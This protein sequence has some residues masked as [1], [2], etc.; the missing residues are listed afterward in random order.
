[1]KKVYILLLIVLLSAC[2]SENS[3]N[4]EQFQ[5]SLDSLNT[6]MPVI[7]EEAVKNILDQIPSP[8]EISMLLRQTN[9][10][11]H[12]GILNSPANV[13]RYNTQFKKAL[14][15]GIYGA[16]L[17]YSN[18]YGESM[19]SL[20]YLSAIKSL[21]Q[22]LNIGQFFDLQAIGRLASNSNNLDS[23]LLITTQN[24]ND[25]NHYLQSQ[26]RSNLSLLFLVGGWVEAMGIL[27]D[28]AA[29]NPGQLNLSDGI[30]A[31][32]IV[33]EQLLLLLSLYKADS[34]MAALLNDFQ[35]L[36]I[37]FDAVNIIRTYKESSMEVIDGIVVIKDN[38]LTT[39]EI[40][41]EEIAAIRT[42]IK[43]IATKITS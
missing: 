35:E 6:S 12:A 27:C 20:R 7:D 43:S 18:I 11:Y 17:G 21:A 32:K 34:N 8:L 37:L 41:D 3:I 25:I 19:E 13:S 33:F 2:K 40:T 29:N 10:K 31:Q 42:K 1:M 30:G 36:K 38:S 14:N 26:N 28:V 16:D 4:E 5:K 15:L 22:D 23:L 39:I 9:A 24:F